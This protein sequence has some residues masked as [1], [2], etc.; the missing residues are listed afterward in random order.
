MHL[1]YFFLLKPSIIFSWTVWGKGFLEAILPIPPYSSTCSPLRNRQNNP[2]HGLCSFNPDTG[3][4]LRSHSHPLTGEFLLLCCSDLYNPPMLPKSFHCVPR[5]V[6]RW[7]ALY[8][9]LSSWTSPLPSSLTEPNCPMNTLNSQNEA[10][11][12]NSLGTPLFFQTITFS[13]FCKRHL[14][15]LIMLLLLLQHHYN[16]PSCYSV[17]AIT[18]SLSSFAED[19]PVCH[20]RYLLCTCLTLSNF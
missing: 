5:S 14:L 2:H 15:L 16:S 8:P 17:I 9:Q 7:L 10:F 20:S 18:W 4:F 6:A 19:K 1:L 13:S 12:S 3:R 11:W